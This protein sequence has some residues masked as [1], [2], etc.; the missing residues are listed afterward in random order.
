MTLLQN[1]GANLL[2]LYGQFRDQLMQ[3]GGAST[4][5]GLGPFL[6]TADAMFNQGRVSIPIM[7]AIAQDT[8]A[9]FPTQNL[10]AKVTYPCLA[11]LA[12]S[13]VGHLIDDLDLLSQ[14][15]GQMEASYRPD[16]NRIRH[17]ILQP[18]PEGGAGSGPG[19]RV[20]TQAE[21]AALGTVQFVLTRLQ[22]IYLQL[23]DVK[24]LF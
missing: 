22:S 2:M 6:D 10:I 21:R 11:D 5:R 3:A 23:N 13:L 14:Q 1:I 19:L 4:E 12:W 16:A 7:R 9:L 15:L 8:R 17:N 18:A 20:Q 24:K